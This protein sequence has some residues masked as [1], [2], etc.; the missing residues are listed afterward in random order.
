M[1]ATA[2]SSA[3]ASVGAARAFLRLPSGVGTTRTDLGCL[4]CLRPLAGPEMTVKS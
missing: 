2:G 3:A 4:G 1:R